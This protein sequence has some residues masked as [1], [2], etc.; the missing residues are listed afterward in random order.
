MNNDLTYMRKLVQDAQQEKDGV[1]EDLEDSRQKLEEERAGHLRT[2]NQLQSARMQLAH[3]SETNSAFGVI[4]AVM[5]I[6]IL[7]LM[8][9]LA[10][11]TLRRKSW[12]TA[13]MMQA[14]QGGNS[15]VVGDAQC[16]SM[17]PPSK[18]QMIC[19]VA[20]VLVQLC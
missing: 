4:F 1:L 6:L 13:P 2:H 17:Q 9:A 10:V 14:T 18:L 12:A 8:T 19:Q 20:R 7:V 11:C 5:A 3:A 15:V 16:K